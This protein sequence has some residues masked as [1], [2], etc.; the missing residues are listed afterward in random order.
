M[1]LWELVARERIR[2]TVATYNWSGDALRLDGVAAAFCA[3]GQLEVRGRPPLRGR[4]AIVA[5]LGGVAGD[6]DTAARDDATGGRPASA[7]G[8]RIVRHHVTNLRFREITPTRAR[9]ECYFAVLTEVGLDHYGRYRDTLVP[10]DDRWLIERRFVSTDWRSPDSSM[11]P[12]D[13]VP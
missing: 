4:D 1:E 2:D 11:A 5:F 6:A 3:D 13:S 10:V 12:P 8:R 7:G 9:T